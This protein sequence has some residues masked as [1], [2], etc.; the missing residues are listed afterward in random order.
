MIK[1]ISTTYIKPNGEIGWARNTLVEATQVK[2]EPT[3]KESYCSLF[4]FNE[5]IRDYLKINGSVTNFKGIVWCE[6]VWIDIDHTEIEKAQQDTLKL[7]KRLNSEYSLSLADIYIYFSGSKGFHIELPSK[8]FGEFEPSND[9]PE[10]IKLLVKELVGDIQTVDYVNYEH[11]RQFRVNNSWNRKSGLYKIEITFDELNLSIEKIKKLAQEPRIIPRKDVNL[12]YKN[13][14][15]Q[16][17]WIAIKNIL[18]V[19]NKVT[20]EQTEDIGFWQPEK[21]GNRNNHLFSQAAMLFDK[22]ELAKGAVYQIISA[23]NQLYKPPLPDF[24]VGLLIDSAFK[25]TLPNKKKKPQELI[26]KPFSGWVDEYLDYLFNPAS[27]MTTGMEC[28]DKILHNHLKGTLGCIVGYGGSKKSLFALNSCLQNVQKYNCVE[29]YSTMEMS[30]IRQMD[31]LIDY[32]VDGENMN[33]SYQ[34][35]RQNRMWAAKFLKENVT[36]LLGSNF[37]MSQNGSLEADHYNK[38]IEKVIVETGRVDGLIVDGLSMMGGKEMETEKYSRNS[39]E[40]KDLANHWNIYIRLICHVSKGADKTTR[41]LTD[42]VRGSEKIFDN[43]DFMFTLSQIED[44]EHSTSETKEYRNDKG[45]IRFYDKRGTGVTI[46]K[47]FNFNPLKLTMTESDDDPSIYETN[48]KRKDK[49]IF[50]SI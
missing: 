47:I 8:L 39:K 20:K 21:Q 12:I 11:V 36:P 32:L 25:K 23:M 40:L 48:K 4:T 45:Y 15:L 37:Q 31:R 46:N 6:S 16:K 2:R 7:I 41:D 10:R 34:I 17:E 13:E 9:L 38:L 26:I 5:T 42:K 1:E 22:S 19:E 43:C 3:D 27:V 18:L 44:I 24:E 14:G 35:K 33:A 29:L 30:G 28:F 50:E 49:N